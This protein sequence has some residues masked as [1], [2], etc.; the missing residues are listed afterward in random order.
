MIVRIIIGLCL[1]GNSGLVFSESLKIRWEGIV[2]SVENTFVNII[3]PQTLK[4]GHNI[5][6]ES[7][8]VTDELSLKIVSIKNI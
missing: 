3:T 7:V 2:P 8:R 4:T 5:N 1:F 6:V